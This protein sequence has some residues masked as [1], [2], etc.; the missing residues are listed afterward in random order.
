VTWDAN[1]LDRWLANPSAFIPGTTMTFPGIRD[2]QARADVIAYLEAVSEGDAPATTQR[3]M[4]GG[5]QAA[6]TDL[7]KAP[8]EGRVTAL[9]H[10]RDTYTVKT[11]DGKTERVWEFNL[12][13]KTDSSALGPA[14][15]KPV[16]VG[17]GMQGDRASVV[18]AS[19]REISRFIDESC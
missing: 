13:L 4:M 3:G 5:M 1:T 14:P 15:G 17:S 10:C 8:P 7:R 11:A 12:R 16:I 19:P 18:F 6:R 9:K 2:V